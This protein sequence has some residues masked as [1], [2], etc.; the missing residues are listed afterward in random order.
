MPTLLLYF[1]LVTPLSPQDR[2]AAADSPLAVLKDEVKRVLAE[3]RLPFTGEQERE[4]VLMMEDRRKASEDLF[5]TLMDFSAG[6]KQGQDADK[7]RSAIEWMRNEFLTHLQNYLRPEQLT[8]W[9]RHQET[10]TTQ[11][12][13]NAAGQAARPPQRE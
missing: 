10:A 9:S 3:A 8:A 4:I 12:A 11:P 7:L 13:S 5:G 2:P 6:P 1:L